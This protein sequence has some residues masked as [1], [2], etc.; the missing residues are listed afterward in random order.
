MHRSSWS[1]SRG[2]VPAA[3]ICFAQL[4]RAEVAVHGAGATFPA[5]VYLAWAAQYRRVTGVEVHYDA[6]GS[7]AGM[8]RIKSGRVDF[9]ATD[10]PLTISELE[11]AHLTQFPAVIGGVVPVVNI[12]GIKSGALR[13]SGEVL[14]HIYLGDI[15]R[16]DDPAIVALNPR[17]PLPKQN[18][19]VVHRRD[20]SGT[21]YIWTDYLSRSLPKWRAI[22]GARLEIPWTVGVAGIGNDGIAS[23]VQHTRAA[24]GYVE[25]E[26]AEQHRLSTVSVDDGHGV[27]LEPSRDS[28]A[29]PES[30]WPITGT[31]YILVAKAAGAPGRICGALLFF[32]WALTEGAAIAK[33]LN[34]VPVVHDLGPQI[35][36]LRCPR[37]P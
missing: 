9:G 4:S 36:S 1:V 8:D 10:V 31:S 2:L 5:P 35:A 18:I 19:T 6:V 32:D 26:Y 14:A 11:Q 28:F 23:Y 37:G 7:G 13:L 27:F 3:L 25:F 24:L 30:P 17:I 22:W 29:A 15:K 20:A 21:T 12:P 16:W 34:Y 33:G